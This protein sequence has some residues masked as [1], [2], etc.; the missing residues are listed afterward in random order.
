MG[1]GRR[2]FTVNKVT[3]ASKN[4][5][6]D[7]IDPTVPKNIFELF[8]TFRR[9]ET[10]VLVLNAG[11]VLSLLGTCS[12]DVVFLRSMSITGGICGMYYNFTRKPPLKAPIIWAV[13]FAAIHMIKIGEIMLDKANIS[14][15][16]DELNLYET[17]LNDL[18]NS[19]KPSSSYVRR[20][21]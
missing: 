12:S 16:G 9:M 2:K 1:F 19:C 4:A 5:F 11:M 20:L 21:R 6:E 10:G 7:V 17:H 14:F 3:G 15:S 8:N 13:V 18:L